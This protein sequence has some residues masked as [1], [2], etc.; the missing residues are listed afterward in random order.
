[1]NIVIKNFRFKLYIIFFIINIVILNAFALNHGNQNSTNFRHR[2]QSMSLTDAYISASSS[3]NEVAPQY[4]IVNLVIPV[5]GWYGF[6]KGTEN[7]MHFYKLKMP[8]VAP[9]LGSRIPWIKLILTALAITIKPQYNFH[10]GLNFFPSLATP[11]AL[12]KDSV[13]YLKSS[14]DKL[15]PNDPEQQNTIKKINQLIKETEALNPYPKK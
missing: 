1:M 15:N 14:L 13:S 12:F 4:N 11:D 6:F 5:L 2:S 3:I 7:L 9:T 8:A 10:Q